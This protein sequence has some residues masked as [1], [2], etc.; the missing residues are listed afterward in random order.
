[1]RDKFRGYYRPS[2]EEFTEMWRNGIFVL[3]TNVLLNLY[4]Y[5]G[6]TRDQLLQILRGINERVWLPHQVAHEYMKNRLGE[7]HNQNKKLQDFR[8]SLKTTVD[9]VEKELNTL[10]SDPGIEAKDLM[11]E[12]RESFEKLAGYAKDLE[13]TSMGQSNSPEHDQIW[14]AID[15]II[16]DQ[17]GE[18]YSETRQQE[19]FQEG[20][21][22]Y[23]AKTPPGY[24]DASKAG[25]ERFGDLILWFQTIDKAKEESTPIIFITADRKEDWWWISH[26]RAIG[27]R[28][29]LLDEIHK[30][31]KVP[32]YIYTPERFMEYAKT[33]L[34]QEVS[35]EAIGEVQELG[36]REEA[37][38]TIRELR[39]I[40]GVASGT[41]TDNEQQVTGLHYYEGLS[42]QEIAERL[43]ISRQRVAQ[44]LQ[45]AQNKLREE[46]DAEAD[47]ASQEEDRS[48]PTTPAGLSEKHM[49]VIRDAEKHLP[50]ERDMRTIRDA[51]KHFEQWKKYLG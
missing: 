12:V 10:H 50:S 27:P 43:G 29:E 31:A 46:L 15:E 16:A 6:S 39:D 1:M 37:E 38:A 51:A 2:D 33:Y 13:N 32:F 45:E 20:E 23:V 42:R 48:R 21:K 9:G 25:T 36:R 28:P 30:E 22:R 3:D 44:I 40:L 5:S 14:E 34:D 26:G 18:P 47:K 17:I 11:Q 7:I 35:D 41:L 49:R 8:D 19:I 24:E 4:R